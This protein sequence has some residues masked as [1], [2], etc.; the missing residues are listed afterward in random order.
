M[1]MDSLIEHFLI[2]SDLN[3]CFSLLEYSEV[4]R[5]SLGHLWTY[6]F[7][8]ARLRCG[9]ATYRDNVA[10]GNA[11]MLTPTV[12]ATSHL[13]QKQKDKLAES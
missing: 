4:P 3:R 6:E 8:Q 11:S 7:L 1:R 13:F 2:V 10:K 12:P 5:G 9:E